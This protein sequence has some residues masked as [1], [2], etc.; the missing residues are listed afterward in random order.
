MI[1]DDL[2]SRLAYRKLA[3]KSRQYFDS[4][5]TLHISLNHSEHM[6]ENFR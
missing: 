3:T 5:K 4:K 2:K 6:F 1:L